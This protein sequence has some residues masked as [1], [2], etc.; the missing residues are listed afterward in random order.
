M[1]KN[2]LLLLMAIFCCVT[3]MAQVPQGISYQ[4]IAFGTSGA[5]VANGNVGVRISIIDNSIT[6]TAVYAE[7]HTKTT[8]AQ[9]LFNLN[10]GQGTPVTGTFATINW[11]TNNKFLKVEIDPSGGTNYTLVGT[12]QLMSVPYAMAAKS[13]VA[14]AGEGVTLVAPNGTPYQLTVDNNG[15][16]SLPT[17]NTSSGGTPTELYLYGT[18]N[19]WDATNALQLAGSGSGNS[20]T[21]YKYFAAGTQIKF[22][23]APNSSVVYGGNS[24]STSGTLVQNGSAIKITSSGFYRIYMNYNGSQYQYDIASIGANLTYNSYIQMQYNVAG[25]YFYITSNAPQFRF[26]IDNTYYGDNLAD[27]TAE[28]DGAAI[29]SNGTYTYKFYLNVDG[30]ATYTKTP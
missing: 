22:L 10:I 5:P 1:R 23:A 7:T 29:V 13:L 12:N 27:G 2:I 21:G 14:T 28:V 15:Q 19:N 30:S 18:F 6:G 24:N 4:A 26:V 8:N 20:F 16:L 25:N 9:G 17:S 3:V 11:V